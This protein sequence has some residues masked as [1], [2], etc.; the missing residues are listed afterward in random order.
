[1]ELCISIGYLKKSPEGTPRTLEQA[2]NICKEGGISYADYLS[3]V[4][5][6]NWEELAY[7]DAKILSDAG[8]TVHQSHVPFNRYSM[9]DE[10]LFYEYMLRSVE[11]ANILGAT[12]LVIHGDE[13]QTFPRTKEDPLAW[14]IA[15]YTPMAELA[16]KKGIKLAFEN[17]FEDG[18]GGRLRHTSVTEDLIALI[19]GLDAVC[20][21]DYGHGRKQNG[22]KD[23]EEIKKIGNRLACTHVHDNYYDKDL[24]VP[25]FFG[26][27]DWKGHM[28]FLKEIGYKGMLS[29]EPVYGQMPD[30]LAVDYL[31]FMVKI[32]NTLNFLS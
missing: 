26:D 13:F 14:S 11:A 28:A 4:K 2:S 21:W 1:M 25:P 31:K 29:F 22:E 10:S 30:S 8:I 7:Q 9:I 3:P 32:G 27:I 5:E 24:H 23:L 17:V 16:Q 18:N 12:Y 6:D 15:F 20:C 19:D